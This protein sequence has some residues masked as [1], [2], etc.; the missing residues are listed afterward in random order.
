MKLLQKLILILITI[1]STIAQGEVQNTTAPN[2]INNEVNNQSL[3][4]DLKKIRSE[5]EDLEQYYKNSLKGLSEKLDK[6]ITIYKKALFENNKEKTSLYRKLRQ[7]SQEFLKTQ[8]KYKNKLGKIFIQNQEDLYIERINSAQSKE[9]VEKSNEAPKEVKAAKKD[10]DLR[11]GI[12]NE[13]KENLAKTD[14]STIKEVVEHR[15]AS[16][17]LNNERK[18]LY[19]GLSEDAKDFV[20]KEKTFKKTLREKVNAAIKIEKALKPNKDK[21]RNK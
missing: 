2:T 16:I 20:V 19:I 1:T 6:E 15:R 5:I 8:K 4:D 17:K 21:N 11:Q 18:A 10:S 12:I 13:Y 7:E 3:V 14:D 9:V